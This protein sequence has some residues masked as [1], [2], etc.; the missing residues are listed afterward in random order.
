MVTIPVK[1]YAAT[2]D[3]DVRFH[4]VHE[5]DGGRIRYK[6]V[7]EIDGEEVSYDQIAKGLERDDGQLVI[8]T[9]EDLDDLPVAST[10]EIEVDRFIPAEQ[11]DPLLTSRS[12]YMEPDAKALKPYVLLRTALADTDRIAIAKVALRQRES[13]A[14]LRVHGDV[15]VIQTL[16]WPDEVREPEFDVLDKPVTLRKDEQEMAASLVET[17]GG[18]LDPTQYSDGYREALLD[19]V[20]AKSGQE[21]AAAKQ[22]S[23]KEPEP[24]AVTDLVAALRDSVE[25]AKADRNKKKPAARRPRPASA[26]AAPSPARKKRTTASTT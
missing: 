19:L 17:M 9:K 14:A 7:C 11:L 6:R 25:R 2:E 3:R 8:L 26:P 21:P 13:L 5:A 15:I 23:A 12:Y 22:E 18:D 10:H 1:L 16:L 24:A 20:A 4:Q